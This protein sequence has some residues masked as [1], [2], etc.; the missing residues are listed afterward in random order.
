MNK[1]KMKLFKKIGT[2][3]CDDCGMETSKCEIK[4][5]ECEGMA[6]AER[7]FDAYCS[8]CPHTIDPEEEFWDKLESVTKTLKNINE[9]EK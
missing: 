8:Y 4:P 2:E 6:E 3:I 7:L 1:I 5:T 9:R